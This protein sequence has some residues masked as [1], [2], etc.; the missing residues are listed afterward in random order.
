MTLSAFS[1]LVFDAVFNGNSHFLVLFYKLH[2]S[3]K[4]CGM[5]LI[6]SFLQ[7]TIP[8]VLAGM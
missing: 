6:V 3:V 5:F 7:V 2:C 4:E 8:S 1:K